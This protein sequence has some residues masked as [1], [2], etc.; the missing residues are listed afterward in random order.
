MIFND[1]KVNSQ[2]L[3][4]VMLF[5]FIFVKYDLICKIMLVINNRIKNKIKYYLWVLILILMK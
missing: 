5:V 2:V 3:N 4:N 1:L